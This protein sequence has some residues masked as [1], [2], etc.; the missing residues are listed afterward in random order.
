M[1]D[2]LTR[3]RFLARAGRLCGGFALASLSSDRL[4]AE[5]NPTTWPVTCRDA[6][7]RYTGRE[8]CWSAMRAIGADGVEAHITE[9]LLLP[10]LFHPQLQYSASSAAGIKRV[11]ADARAA[12][13]RITAF[14]MFNRLDDRPEKE[15]EWCGRVARVAQALGVPA[16]RID[17]VP[18]KRPRAEFLKHAVDA[19][20]AI[21]RQTQPTGVRFAVEN[22]GNT[23]NDP[24]F[25]KTLFDGV[26]SD[27]LGLTLDTGNFYWFG[28]PLSKVYQWY[29]TFAPRV[30]HT[31]CKSIGYPEDQRQRRRPMGWKYAQYH[32][33]IYEGD[34]D[35]AR[36]LA[37][38]RKAGYTNDLCVE[39]E[40]LGR[41]GADQATETLAREIR[42]LKRL[43]AEA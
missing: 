34:I 17:V 22:H 35:F 14:C 3:R 6:M 33:P 38:L 23:T 15:I 30:F 27:R 16:I 5:Q 24:E 11:A 21:I 1:N 37:I 19:L 40:S 29:E 12:K 9:D 32:V 2:T 31:H 43:R 4:P 20:S 10:G 26:G 36:V 39:N 7:L 41:L 25:L 28:H 13:R 18:S 42:L 8:D